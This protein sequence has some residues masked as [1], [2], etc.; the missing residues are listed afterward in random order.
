MTPDGV[1]DHQATLLKLLQQWHHPYAAEIGV[2]SGRTSEYL[3]K[4]HSGL[5]LWMVDRWDCVPGSRRQRSSYIA[6]KQTAADRTEFAADRR[7][8]VHASSAWAAATMVDGFFD[9]IFIDAHHE[10][11]SVIEDMT[12]W[13]SRLRA[14]GVYCGHDIDS[15]KDKRG[16]WG[17]RKAVEEFCG[18]R[19]LEFQ[20]DKNTWV[21]IKP[22]TVK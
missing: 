10:Y 18:E 14:G 9:L 17:V 12:V 16:V 20:V 13:W 7:T 4:N 22:P 1:F 11:A 8:I 15:P 5:R 19:G 3:L 21:L 6:A 2:A